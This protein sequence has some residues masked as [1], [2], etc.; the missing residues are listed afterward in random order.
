MRVG[1]VVGRNVGSDGEF[2]WRG[3]KRGKKCEEVGRGGRW[4]GGTGG[5]EEERGGEREKG[6]GRRGA[7]DANWRETASGANANAKVKKEE[8]AIPTSPQP[9]DELPTDPIM[10]AR[11]NEL[12]EELNQR[13]LVQIESD[14][15]KTIQERLDASRQQRELPQETNCKSVCDAVRHPRELL[16]AN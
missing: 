2:L 10:E 15:Q 3:K 12:R 1:Y 14:A 9:T 5:G 7:L 8:D 13:R 16:P 11:L 4:G 6:G